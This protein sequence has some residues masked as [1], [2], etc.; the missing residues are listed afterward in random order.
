MGMKIQ[1]TELTI[2]GKQVYLCRMGRP[3]GITLEVTNLGAAAVSLVLPDGKPGADILLGFSGPEEQMK[4]GPM[5]GATLGR[6]AGKIMGGSYPGSNGIVELT[7]SHGEHHA[8]G[9]KRG[10]D[11][12]VFDLAWASE[13]SISFHY[14]SPAGEEGYPGRLEAEVTYVLRDAH[15]LEVIYDVRSDEETPAGL[16][17]HM[18]FNLSEE[19]AGSVLPQELQIDTPWVQELDENGF[20]AGRLI[21]VEGGLDFRRA[22]VIGEQLTKGHEQLERGHGLDLDYV[23]EEG[24]GTASLYCRQTGRR[25]SVET[26]MPCIHVYVSDFGQMN[27]PGKDGAVYAGVCGVCFQTMYVNDCLHS[28]LGRSPMLEPGVGRRAQT[29][30]H[31]EWEDTL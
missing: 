10:F 17:N 31:F 28:G 24:A 6:Y 5:F 7:R 18:Y 29:V 23:F 25:M 19:A 30:F 3:G 16:S 15:T 14:S 4:K 11:K 21:R 13:E 1:K 22:A 8:H 2:D 27:Y 9:G 12:Q 26:D 20:P